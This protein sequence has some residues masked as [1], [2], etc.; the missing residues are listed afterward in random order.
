MK[1]RITGSILLHFT[2][3]LTGLHLVAFPYT[4]GGK[5]TIDGDIVAMTN[6]DIIQAVVLED[7]GHFPIENGTCLG[8][9]LATDVNALVVQTHV[10]G[11]SILSV[12]SHDDVW[13]GNRHRQD[14]LVFL[15]TTRQLTVFGVHAE[16]VHRSLGSGFGRNRFLGG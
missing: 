9:V 7:G 13:T 11:H 8:T 12:S 5:V 15:E 6:Q 2:D 10:L 3:F 1:N 16:L 14:A 4:D